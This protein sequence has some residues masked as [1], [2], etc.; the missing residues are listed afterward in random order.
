MLHNSYEFVRYCQSEIKIHLKAIC[1][2]GE[3]HKELV[4]SYKRFFSPYFIWKNTVLCNNK[5]QHN[6]KITRFG[7]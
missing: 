3:N 4:H 1:T 5:M 2:F 7:L 6:V